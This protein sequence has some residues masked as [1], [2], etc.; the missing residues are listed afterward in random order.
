MWKFYSREQ[1]CK[2][3]SLRLFPS[4][5]ASVHPRWTKEE[6][7]KVRQWRYGS[8]VQCYL[9]F[10]LMWTSQ[11]L[12]ER[13]NWNGLFQCGFPN[14]NFLS[15]FQRYY[16]LCS[17]LF[18]R[19]MMRKDVK[20]IIPP[21]DLPTLEDMESLHLAMNK[22]WGETRFYSLISDLYIGTNAILTY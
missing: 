14:S 3:I 4:L 5:T 19:L 6:W 22:V 17:A 9:S 1:S 2:S 15:L 20:V 12:L 7:W 21:S 8:Y 18:Q 13:R 16:H 11:F 10:W